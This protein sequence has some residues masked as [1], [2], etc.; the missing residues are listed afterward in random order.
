MKYILGIETSCDD[1]AASVM[2]EEGIILSN[3]LSSQNAFHA[4]YGGIVP[5][6]ASRKHLD[7]LSCVVK[8][9]CHLASLSLSQIDLLAV[10]HG[11]GLVGSL[12]IGVDYVKALSVALNKPFV[13]VNHLEGHLLSPFLETPTI[14]FPFLGVIVSGGH[15][16]LMVVSDFG[17]YKKVAETID[18]ACGEALDKFGKL[19]SIP[20][21]AGALIEKI[22]KVGNPK[23]YP[24][25]MP[26]IR[27]NWY[28][29]S[30]SGIKTAA[31]QIIKTIPKEQ[32]TEKT[33][34]LCASY[35]DALFRQIL[36]MIHRMLDQYQVTGV[37]VSG[38]VSAN[39]TM[40]EM[41]SSKISLPLYFPSKIM[42]TDNAGMIAFAGW[43]KFLRK[44]A[45]SLTL[46]VLSR[47]D[48]G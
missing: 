32:L 15:T 37:A 11:P 38:G 8:E 22:A 27:D 31:S 9:A 18:D 5:E 47:L 13:G 28:G 33:P 14:K 24:F 3:V 2:T 46:P 7:L 20:Y 10:T 34:D 41:F 23:A 44:G 36:R 42:S 40:A 6:I 21:P 26:I 4:K 35:Q 48:I 39:R 43:K 45:D 30:F 16:V 25:T 1:T 19:L 29:L 17:E 12:L